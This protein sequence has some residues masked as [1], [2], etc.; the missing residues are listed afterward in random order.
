MFGAKKAR[1]YLSDIVENPIM[2]YPSYYKVAENLHDDE[3]FL[4]A[5]RAVHLCDFAHY[6]KA[7]EGE[8]IFATIHAGGYPIYKEQY[9]V[10]F[11][12]GKLMYLEP[13]GWKSM[14]ITEDTFKM[15]NWLV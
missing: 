14:P 5:V 8:D 9:I 11:F 2:T 6:Q 12:G 7:S 1:I 3:I 15:E 10:G 4:D 13:A